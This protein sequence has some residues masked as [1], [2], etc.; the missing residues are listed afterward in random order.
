MASLFAPRDTALARFDAVV[1]AAGRPHFDSLRAQL[2]EVTRLAQRGSTDSVAVH[3]ARLAVRAQVLGRALGCRTRGSV[4]TCAGAMGDLATF[5]VA[6]RERATRA[7]LEAAGI[8]IDGVVAREL[9]APGDTVPLTIT[10]RNGGTI[11]VQFRSVLPFHQN[12]SAAGDVAKPLTL[13]PD[14]LAQLPSALMLRT[15]SRHWW[16]M[17]GLQSGTQLHLSRDPTPIAVD[18]RR[19][20]SR[21]VRGDGAAHHRRSR[22]AGHRGAA[23]GPRTDRAARRH[24]ASGDRCGRDVAAVRTRRRIRTRRA[25]GEPGV[26]GVRAVGTVERRHRAGDPHTARRPAGRFGGTRGAAGSIRQPQHF[27]RAAWYAVARAAAD[28]GQRPQRARAARAGH[29]CATDCRT[30]HIHARHGD[31][32]LPAHPP[33]STSYGSRATGWSPLRCVCHHGCGSATC[34]ARKTCAMRS[35]SCACR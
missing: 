10:I 29:R 18:P 26:P 22:G 20:P 21:C 5:V 14:S 7:M 17:F 2:A 4:P 15:I 16:Q 1:P 30:H 32:R 31:Q 35:A 33:R 8:V 13:A 12:G 19:G 27:L 24:A 34:A 23:G 11:P 6:V 25:A 28:R 9:V 3:L